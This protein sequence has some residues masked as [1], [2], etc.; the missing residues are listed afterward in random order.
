VR[1][2]FPDLFVPTAFEEGQEKKYG[3][4]FLIP[5]GSPL[6]K[7]IERAIKEVAAA[8]WGAKAQAVLDSIKGVPNKYCFCDGDLKSE[9]DGYEGMMSLSAKNSARPLVTDLD[10]TPLVAEDGRPYAGCYVH[11][12]VELWAQDNK[13]GKGIRA[14]LRAVMF[15]KDGDAFAG[16]APASDDEFDDLTEGADADALV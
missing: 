5:K 14:K 13:W 8:K 12:S 2:A 3:A 10:K 1:L 6:T 16:G 9:Y 4:T 15:Y 7:E 11:G